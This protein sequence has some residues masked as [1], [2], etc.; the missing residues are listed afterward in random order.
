VAL[1]LKQ[2]IA[3]YGTLG[4]LANSIPDLRA[5]LEQGAKDE[6]TPDRFWAEIQ[7]PYVAQ[8][9]QTLEINEQDIDLGDAHIQRALSD[10]DEKGTPRTEPLWAFERR[11][12]DDPRWDKT[13]QASNQ[14]AD[15]L[16]RIGQDWGYSA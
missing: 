8:M 11:L 1:D 13:K 7:Q 2:A 6:W 3:Q 12:K 16:S 14:A 9:A 4:I 5:K 15:M 10:R